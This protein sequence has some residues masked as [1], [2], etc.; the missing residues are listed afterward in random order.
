MDSQHSQEKQS[1]QNISSPDKM[2]NIETQPKEKSPMNNMISIL[3]KVLS[4]TKEKFQNFKS[5]FENSKFSGKETTDSTSNNKSYVINKDFLLKDHKKETA[6]KVESARPESN[7]KDSSFTQPLDVTVRETWPVKLMTRKQLTDPFGSDEEDENQDVLTVSV[8][9]G[10]LRQNQKWYD[11]YFDDFLFLQI[12]KM[13]IVQK[14][15]KNPMSG[16]ST[17]AKV[18]SNRR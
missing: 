13:T 11:K 16:N 15:I 8:N 5:S 6:A 9:E 2:A 14:L 17:K 12:K 3:G 7:P 10:N 4:P 1:A 18:A